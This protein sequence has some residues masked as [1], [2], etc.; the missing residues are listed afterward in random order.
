MATFDQH[1]EEG[2]RRRRRYAVLK[3]GH[4][5]EYTE[6]TYGGYASMLQRLLQSKDERWVIFSVIDGDF[7]FMDDPN[8]FDGFVITGS[9]ADAHSND[10]DWIPRLSHALLTL[11]RLNKKLLGICFG[12]QILAR[13]LGGKTGRAS[14]GW[15][16]GIKK[17]QIDSKIMSQIY[18]VEMSPTLNVIE[19]HRDQVL[20][21]P[22]GAIVLASSEKTEIEMFAVG[23]CVLGIQCHPEF[24]KDVML[25]IIH[26]RLS[27]DSFSAEVAN[28]AIGSL[29]KHQPDQ[30]PLQFLCKRFLK[31]DFEVV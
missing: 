2:R 10:F 11:H 22:P 27:G 14:V 7:S 23:D 1:E 26:C 15:E 16:I 30:H 3:T 5:T 19:S 12:H 18:G 13:A 29:E 6:L 4:A 28:E 17:L 9:S 24:S 25:D 20:S 21:V 31:G 8:S